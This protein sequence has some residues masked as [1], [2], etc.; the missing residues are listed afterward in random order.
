[1]IAGAGEYDYIQW[2]I[3]HTGE[4]Y[5]IQGILLQFQLYWQFQL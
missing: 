3:I 4:Y 5:Y 2:N 1:M